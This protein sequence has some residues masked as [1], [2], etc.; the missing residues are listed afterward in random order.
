MTHTSSPDGEKAGE[1]P[2]GGAALTAPNRDV[3]DAGQ[4]DTASPAHR[5]RWPIWSESQS[6]TICNVCGFTGSHSTVCPWGPMP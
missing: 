5:K 3:G 4:P 2:I 6:T 1:R